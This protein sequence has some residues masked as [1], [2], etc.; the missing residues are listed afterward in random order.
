MMTKHFIK[1]EDFTKKEYLELLKISKKFAGGGDFS[2]ICRG[3]VMACLFFQESTHTLNT[4]KTAMIRLGGG[5]IGFDGVKGTF[6]G[7]GEE[8]KEDTL[9]VF[10]ELPDILVIRDSDSATLDTAVRVS[11]VPVI[12][13]GSG[14]EE[15]SSGAFAY[16][17]YV[18]NKL[19]R[20]DGL[21]ICLYGAPGPS[22]AAKGLIKFFSLFNTKIY[23]DITIPELDLPNSIYD[24]AKQHKNKIIKTKLKDI[25]GEIDLLIVEGIPA[26]YVDNNLVDKY[27]STYKPITLNEVSK[28]KKNAI[29]RPIT[30]RIIKGDLLSATKDVDNDPRTAFHDLSKM[31]SFANMALIVKLLNLKV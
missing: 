28:M 6:V 30:P 14:T 11:Q 12:N 20:I 9:R 19:G 31:W 4:F 5:V 7:S 8:D 16:G 10:S 3:K 27:I 15:H 26:K 18:F 2:H 24:F 22:R 17:F 21:K 1:V 25:I 29:F 23:T 13:G